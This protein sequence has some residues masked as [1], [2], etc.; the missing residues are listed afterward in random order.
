MVTPREGDRQQ[1]E[2]PREGDRRWKH[3]AG[4]IWGG[5]QE[6]LAVI[7]YDGT[8][9]I[10]TSPNHADTV[11]VSLALFYHYHTSIHTHFA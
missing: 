2:T 6:I 1:M 11:A 4:E 3:P 8:R 5:R 10:E 9:G 7:R